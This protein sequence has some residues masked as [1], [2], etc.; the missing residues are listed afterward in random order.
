M[1]GIINEAIERLGKEKARKALFH[2]FK[3][4]ESIVDFS[5]L[6]S[7]HITDPQP[8]FHQNVLDF[9]LQPGW[10][11][12]AAPRGFAKSTLV[13]IFLAG[14]HALNAKKHFILIIS[15]T[16]TQAKLHLGGLKDELENNELINWIWGDVVGEV[17]GEER[18]VVNSPNGKVMIMALG[19]GMKIRGLKYQQYRPELVI[20]DDLENTEMVYSA[21]R[22]QKVQR[23]FDYDLKSG[24]DKDGD[25]IYLGT[26]LHYDSLLKKVVEKKEQ[27]QSWKTL[28]YKALTNGE[29]IWP[30]R[31]STEYLKAIRD[32][33]NHPKYV[34]SLVFAQEYQN[35]PQDDKDRIIQSE[36]IKTYS[37]AER[38]A[39][40]PGES[41]EEKQTNFFGRFSEIIAAVDPAIG[42]KEQSDFFS[43][44]I[45]GVEKETSNEYQLDLL[46]GKFTIDEQVEKIMGMCKKWQVRVLGI[47]SNAYQ[48]GL[49]QLVRSAL[50]KA[51]LST[52]IIKI[53]TDK[54]KIRRAKIHSVA[55]EGGFIYL[56]H[57]Q[58]GFDIIK[59][60]IVEF[61]LAAH[62]DTFDSLM[63]ARETKN[64]PN[65]A[66]AFT[67]KPAGL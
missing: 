55:F 3:K 28:K 9:C 67:S 36:W 24:V 6:F 56:R 35:E 61:P 53:R 58:R 22:R 16:I 7:D 40:T 34:G 11:A 52:R 17:W 54:D 37:Y 57:D 10:K 2:Y 43:M 15:D 14:W 26:I 64:R 20:I 41:E 47:E 44:Y 59:T 50:H 29:S 49:F 33:S 13:N 8:S 27:Y 23:W 5:G 45:M 1:A 65:K 19:A 25:I 21:E 51:G 42:D 31:Y 63:L 46:R 39:N 48:A 60:E 38:L 4:P 62:D 66:R 30:Q 32:D 12:I 18:I